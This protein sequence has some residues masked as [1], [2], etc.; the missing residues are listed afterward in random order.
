MIMVAAGPPFCCGRLT[1]RNTSR[2]DFIKKYVPKVA[3]VL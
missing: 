3:A 2:F 1:D